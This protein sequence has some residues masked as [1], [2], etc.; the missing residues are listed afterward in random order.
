MN[1][2]S[3][4]VRLLF[5]SP[6]FAFGLRRVRDITTY[7]YMYSATRILHPIRSP[8]PALFFQDKR[9]MFCLLELCLQSKRTNLAFFHTSDFLI[10]S[11]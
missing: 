7:L 5:F 11:L 4:M 10:R 3:A 2:N 8:F 6:S 9:I 1:K